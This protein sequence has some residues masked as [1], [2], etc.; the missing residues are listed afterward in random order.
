VFMGFGRDQ[1]RRLQGPVG[2]KMT[3]EE[4]DHYGVQW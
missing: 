4:Q 2:L 1:E 3:D